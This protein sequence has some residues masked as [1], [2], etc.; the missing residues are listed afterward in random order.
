VNNERLR[1]WRRLTVL[2]GVIQLTW[3]LAASAAVIPSKES[4]PPGASSRQAD[5]A[6]VGAVVEREEVAKAL[7]ARGLAPDEVE[8]RLARLSDQDLRSLA[9][10]IDQIQAAGDV[11]RYIWLLLAVLIAVI[12]LTTVF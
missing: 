3:V 12:I 1:A 10:N 5:L 2:L 7:A 9:T 11:P 8:L 6:R 4:D